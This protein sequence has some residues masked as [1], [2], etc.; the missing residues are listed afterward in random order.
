MQRLKV[1]QPLMP[2][3]NRYF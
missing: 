1:L 2:I 3:N